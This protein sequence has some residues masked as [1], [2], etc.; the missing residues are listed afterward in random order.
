MAT[1]TT[2][3]YALSKFGDGDTGWGAPADANMDTLDA[4]LAKPRIIYQSP[5]VGATTTC[6]LAQ[7]RVFVFTVSQVTTIAFANVPTSA[8]AVR[9]RL[10]ITNGAAFAVTFPASVTWLAGI[11]PSF[12]AA[13]TD[14]VELITKDGGTTWF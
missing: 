4:E 9:V 5:T 8:F 11:A 1:T 3:N 12:K 2:P 10:L 13:G 14:E 7:G 6:D